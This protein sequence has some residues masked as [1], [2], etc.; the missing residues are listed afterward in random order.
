MLYYAKVSDILDS[1]VVVGFAYSEVLL[2]NPAVLQQLV[3]APTRIALI[4]SRGLA[5]AG[6]AANRAAA[7]LNVAL[8]GFIS[9]IG[10]F[11]F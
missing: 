8:D 2:A 11:A 9:T 1:L 3:Y 4:G 10:G 7:E 6:A 5:A